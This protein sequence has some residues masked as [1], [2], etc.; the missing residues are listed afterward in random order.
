MNSLHRYISPR[1]SVASP[2]S[3][4]ISPSITT[5]TSSNE[6]VS[7]FFSHKFDQIN[8]SNRL[9]TDNLTAQLTHLTKCVL[10]SGNCVVLHASRYTLRGLCHNTCAT[11][12]LSPNYLSHRIQTVVISFITNSNLLRKF[13]FLPLPLSLF[14]FLPH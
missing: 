5:S 10:I 1:V 6:I 8:L 11:F 2:R 14:L 12:F 9:D 4:C 13:F 7:T 3:I